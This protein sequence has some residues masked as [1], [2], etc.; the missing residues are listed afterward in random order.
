MSYENF[1]NGGGCNLGQ[2][3]FI[4]KEKPKVKKTKINK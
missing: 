1:A 3:K 2:L 4:R